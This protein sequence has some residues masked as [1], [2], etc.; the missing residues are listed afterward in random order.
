[1][2]KTPP[3]QDASD[4]DHPLA[5]P[6]RPDASVDQSF[7]WLVA[8]RPQTYT[9]FRIDLFAK[10]GAAEIPVDYFYTWSNTCEGVGPATPAAKLAAPDRAAK[11]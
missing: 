11:H 6:F 4:A 7:T 9:L 2:A 10:D 3:V 5:M 1:M 8:R